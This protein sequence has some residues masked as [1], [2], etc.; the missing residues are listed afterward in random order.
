MKSL[1]AR[2]FKRFY[3]QIFLSRLF[4]LLSG[5]LFSVALPALLY[6]GPS[7]LHNVNSGQRTALL[8]TSIAFVLSHFSTKYILVNYPGGQSQGL[9]FTQVLMCY[10]TLIIGTLLLRTEVSR[11]LLVASG[12]AALL[13]VHIEYITT[14]AY[15]RPKFA[16]IPGGFA[17]EVLALPDCDARLLACL[18]LQGVRYDG[19]VADFERIDR[20]AERFLTT[21]ALTNVPVYN[22]KSVYETLSGRVKIDKMSENNIGSLLPSTAYELTKSLID[23]TIVVITLPIVL[24][25]S[26]LTACLIRLESP[27]PA[28]YKQDRVGRGNRVFTIYKF[29]S[30]RFD[31]NAT[32]QFAGQDDPRVTRVGRIIRKLRIDEVPQFFNVLKGEMS[33]IGPRPEQPS[34]VQ[35]FDKKIPFYSYRHVVKPGITGWAQVRHGY[36]AGSDETRV[37]IEHDFYYI[38]NCSLSLDFFIIFLTFRTM[39]T[40]FGAR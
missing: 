38:K 23:W 7:V 36:A 20:D 13:W 3:E 12:V 10:G 29:R 28:I 11:A 14:R 6:W 34:F 31:R 5:W 33:L 27:G 8:A 26:V 17:D 30:M 22:A 2:R 24:P 21:C 9:I 37:K 15:F 4:A 1:R 18:D 16:I 19:I 39:L 35:E 40:G 32:E 25:L